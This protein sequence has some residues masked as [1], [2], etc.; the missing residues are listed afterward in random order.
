MVAAIKRFFTC[1]GMLPADLRGKEIP[2]TRSVYRATLDMAWPSAVESVLV[3]LVGIIDTMMVGTLGPEAIAAVGITNQPKFIFLAVI[4]SLNVGVTAVVARRRG[5]NDQEKANS[6]L[7][8]TIL[9]SVFFSI[10]SSILGIVF[11]RPIVSFAGAEAD[12]LDDAVA[13][14][15]I[16]MGG[17][18]FNCVLLTMNAAQ[19]GVGNTRISMRTNLTANGVN[20]VLNY[21]LI[22]GHLGFPRLGVRGAAIATIVGFFVGFLM[23]LKS[24]LHHGQFL[25]LL[26]HGSWRF[27]AKTLHSIWLVSS[28]SLFEQLCMRFGFFTYVKIVASLGT[29]PF[30][31]HQICMNILTLSFCFGD[32]L[33]IAASSLVG[34]SLGEKRSDLAIVYGKACQRIALLVSFVLM[35]LFFFFR[36]PVMMAFTTD[37]GIIETGK[38]IVIIIGVTTFIQTSQVVLMGCLRGAGDT[39]FAAA[40]SL[41]SIAFL[42]PGSAWLFCYPMGLGLIGAWFSLFFDQLIRMVF[43]MVRFNGGKWT[44]HK[45]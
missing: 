35:V 23:S 40:V 25:S 15:Q 45:L 14:F 19:R 7:R 34:R 30:A 37:A 26:S 43:S 28:S 1:E 13:Y 22:G 12:I 39:M 41:L 18:F 3:G 9:I 31:T 29:I 5:E 11:A 16:L 42:R 4:L 10:L 38:T 6:V 17:M 21:L 24:L 36:G 8:Q 33:S 2:D 20:I 32:G 27:D 44:Q